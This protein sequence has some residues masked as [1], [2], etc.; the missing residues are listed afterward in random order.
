L[1]EL[2]YKFSIQKNIWTS[3]IITDMNP[4]QLRIPKN[5]IRTRFVPR[6]QGILLSLMKHIAKMFKQ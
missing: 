4:M 3:V 5:I 2:K 6:Y 1:K